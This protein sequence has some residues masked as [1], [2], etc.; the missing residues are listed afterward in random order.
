MLGRAELCYSGK[1]FGQ[2]LC[3]TVVGG[4]VNL[5]FPTELSGQDDWHVSGLVG[6]FTLRG[7]VQLYE[8]HLDQKE[9]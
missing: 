7:S 2:T 1:H 5:G 8:S 9:N 6:D 4:A 3:V